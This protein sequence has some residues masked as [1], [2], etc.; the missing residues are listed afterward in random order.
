MQRLYGA[1]AGLLLYSPCP[2]S[3]GGEVRSLTHDYRR[4]WLATHR[5]PATPLY[6]SIVGLPLPERVSAVCSVF[7]RS[8]ARIDPHN[9]GQMLYAD[10][11]LPRSSL[12]GYAN[13][14]HFAIALP[15]A[16][17]L[18]EARLLGINRHDFPRAQ[19]VEAA[20]RIAQ[21]RLMASAGQSR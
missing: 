7:R 3:D 6:F 1:T 9:D 18:P 15:I 2:G 11:I 17:A 16:D 13:A 4:N 12:L 14:D 5:L 19:L 21:A 8:L 10:A 20:I